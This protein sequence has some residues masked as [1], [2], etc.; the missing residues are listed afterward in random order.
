[1]RWKFW[2]LLLLLFAGGYFFY[3]WYGEQLARP[4]KA[5]PVVMDT[6]RV[7]WFSV[8]PPGEEE[9]WIFKREGDTW[10]LS[11]GALTT[12]T[13]AGWVEELLGACAEFESDSIVQR[14]EEGLFEEQEAFYHRFYEGSRLLEAYWLWPPGQGETYAHAYLRPYGQKEVF[15]ISKGDRTA[16][17]R[18]M[19]KY[20]ARA[21]LP[22][23]QRELVYVA[24]LDT[25]GFVRQ[26]FWRDSLWVDE[27]ERVLERFPFGGLRQTFAVQEF[28]HFAQAAPVTDKRWSLLL[29]REYLVVQEVAGDTLSDLPKGSFRLRSTSDLSLPKDAILS[30]P[31]DAI[32]SLPKEVVVIDVYVDSLQTY[33][34]VFSSNLHPG[35]YFAEDSTGLYLL[36]R[37]LQE[38]NQ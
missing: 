31:K 18:A 15:L 14:L 16:C 3:R 4:F 34:F 27:Q 7:D 22:F 30:L 26:A 21:L 19:E 17:W 38:E 12:G 6:S 23:P 29:S 32:L 20:R 33:P 1:M 28:Q 11:H 9:E 5:R 36:L 10:L 8:L 37:A 2:F 24:L 13:K 35:Q 25:A